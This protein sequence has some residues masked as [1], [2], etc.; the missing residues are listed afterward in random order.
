MS[1]MTLAPDLLKQ[2]LAGTGPIRL[3]AR[4]LTSRPNGLH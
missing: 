3:E 2:L 4:D 1:H